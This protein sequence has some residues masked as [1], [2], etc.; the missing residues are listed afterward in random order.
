MGFGGGGERGDFCYVYGF[1]SLR[2]SVCV[3]LQVAMASRQIAAS[4]RL[5]VPAGQAKPA[6]PVGPALGQVRGRFMVVEV[7]VEV[8][9]LDFDRDLFLVLS[10]PFPPP[11]AGINIM[12]FCKEFNARTQHLRPGTPVPS[13]VTVF[14]DKSFDFTVRSPPISWLLKRVAG[15]DKGARRPG[16][17]LVGQVSLKHVYAVAEMKKSDGPYK[18]VPMEAMCRTVMAVAR[19]IGLEVVDPRRRAEG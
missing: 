13:I 14:N 6:P 12:S 9:A 5:L 16:H 3:S 1:M 7:E 18:H 4:L 10:P 17:E 11:Q 8:D 15:V 19:S 2:V